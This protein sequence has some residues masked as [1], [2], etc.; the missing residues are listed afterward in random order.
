MSIPLELDEAAIMTAVARSN[1][2]RHND[3]LVGRQPLSRFDCDD[4]WND[5]LGI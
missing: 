2:F 4:V 3:S 1:C 5:F